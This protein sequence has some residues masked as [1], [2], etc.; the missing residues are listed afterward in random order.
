[1]FLT[2]IKDG[3]EFAT[4][5]EFKNYPFHF[6]LFHPEKLPTADLSNEQVNKILWIR[7][8]VVKFMRQEIINNNTREELISHG[9]SVR[10]LKHF[11]TW[12]WL[13]LGIEVEF[14]QYTPQLWESEG[15]DSI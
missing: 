2:K 4:F 14:Y 12:N 6:S 9:T 1:M 8:S 11:H 10:N 15:D 13:K 7:E 3:V 5:F